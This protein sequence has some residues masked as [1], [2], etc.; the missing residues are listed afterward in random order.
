MRRSLRLLVLLLFS[1]LPAL[2]AGF[3]TQRLREIDTTIERAIA[4]QQIPGGVFWLER[5]GEIYSKPYGRRSVEPESEPM[6]LDTIFDA[7]SLTK[8]MA[9]TPAVV[10]LVEEGKI[11]LDSPVSRYIPEFSGNGREAVTV[12][13]LLTHT[14][15]LRP[16]LIATEWTGYA[17]GIE[18]AAA[19]LPLHT[20]GTNFVYSDINYLLLGEIVRRVSGEP[21]HAFAQ[22]RIYRPLQ[23]KD[24]G[25]LPPESK[26]SRIA[27]TERFEGEG[28]L[29]GR[30]HDPTSRRMDGVAGSAGLFTTAH[31]LAR[32][33]RMLL[34]EG[35]LEGVRVL[36]PETIQLMTAVNT[37]SALW[38]RRGLGWDLDS[39]YSRPR[40]KTFPLGSFGHTGWTGTFVWIDP[41]SDTFYLFLSNRVHPDGKGDVIAMQRVLGTLAAEAV[42]GVDFASYKGIGPRTSLGTL[43]G[44][45]VL[46]AEKFATLQGLK[47]GL[48]TNHTGRSRQGASTI[49]LL[50]NAPGVKLV[51]LFSPEHGIRG[52][53]DEK[54]SDDR[55][56]R[57]GLPIFSLY[58]ETRKPTLEQ[59]DGLDALVFDVQDIGARFYTYPSTMGLAMEAAGEAKIRFFVLD[60][61]NPITGQFVEGPLRE[62]EGSFIAWHPIVV[63]HGM[64]IGELA[65]MFKVE[66]NLPVDLTVIKLQKWVR[67][68]W[69]DE[70]GIPWINP[71]PNMRSLNAATLYPGVCLL[72]RT[73]FSVGRGTETPFEVIG[74]PY[75]NE[76]VLADAMESAVLPGI[77]FEPV[78][79]TPNAS[80]FKGQ[81][82]GGVRMRITNRDALRSVDLGIVLAQTLHRLYPEHFSVGKVNDL[83]R[84]PPTI[85][86]IRAGENL[87]AIRRIWAAGHADFLKRRERFLLY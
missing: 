38:V 32:Y 16:G 65:Q 6:T 85:E 82:C 86:G 44:I 84:H 75:V 5:D 36:K 15:G 22:R 3:S 80:V 47:I 1:A 4:E 74:A 68:A 73:E 58:G 37:P 83:L 34:S 72:E 40:G 31:D 67:G 70:T 29:R 43:N 77:R 28:I 8:V 2:S 11:D 45:D 30:V 33:A 64:T 24:T 27:P 14:S 20:P 61:I 52:D 57:T 12:R 9:T 56:S 49:D 51:A 48:I 10:I 42:T 19:E 26:R 69:Q 23:M 17:R 54:V 78:R 62:G 53:R 59:L 21:L 79:F 35:K 63:R 25:F 13:Q 41:H 66:R 46:V 60:R 55:D 18:L 39:T 50:H 71:S 87:S 7:A 76:K 81:A